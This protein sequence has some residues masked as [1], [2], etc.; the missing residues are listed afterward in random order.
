MTTLEAELQ[1]EIDWR[2]SEIS[3]IRTIPLIGNLKDYQNDIIIKYATVAVY[4]LWEG[5]VVSSLSQYI[6]EVNKLNINAKTLHPSIITHDIDIKYQFGNP[7]TD[8]DKKILLV[9]ELHNYLNNPI[10]LEVTIPTNSNV[11]FKMINII[12][13]RLNIPLMDDK[14]RSPLNKLVRVRNDIAHGEFSI[15]TD[16]DLVQELSFTAINAMSDLALNI[17]DAYTHQLFLR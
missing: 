9:G 2:V 17:I 16:A 4:S 7:R 10:T 1:H 14:Y 15:P 3:I 13:K 6:R 8:F 11:H 12:L 5:F